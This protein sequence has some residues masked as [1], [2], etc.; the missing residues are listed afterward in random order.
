[1]AEN[2]TSVGRDSSESL[3]FDDHMWP[4]VCAI[5]I[6]AGMVVGWMIPQCDF[7][8]PRLL[9]NGYTYVGA[10]GVLTV[11]MIAAAYRLQAT[12]RRRFLLCIVLSMVVHVSVAI[13]VEAWPMPLHMADVPG[14]IG[15]GAQDEDDEIIAPDYH[16]NQAEEPDAEE[17]FEAPVAT[18]VHDEP[19]KLIAIQP[20]DAQRPVPVAEVPRKPGVDLNPLGRGGPEEPGGPIEPLRPVE[21]RRAAAANMPEVAP[22][23]ALAMARET[24]SALDL[25]KVETEPA[26]PLPEAKPA[27]KEL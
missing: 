5:V 24:R 23:D 15:G 2:T 9:Y 21:M 25:P 16:W 4:I 14:G 13:G 27:P 17:A 1:M 8:D 10:V 3:G 18:T 22:P 11:L 19:P 26:V 20:R 12:F 7:D 6:L